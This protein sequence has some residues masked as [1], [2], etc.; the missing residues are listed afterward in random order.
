MMSVTGLS[1]LVAGTM[2]L[3]TILSKKKT[4]LVMVTIKG[5]VTRDGVRPPEII[6][7]IEITTTMVVIARSLMIAPS[8]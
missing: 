3:V 7:I 2:C 4:G 6:M 1:W 8:C 5:M